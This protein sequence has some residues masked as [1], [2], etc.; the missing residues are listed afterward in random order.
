[1]FSILRIR[2]MVQRA[3]MKAY[4]KAQSEFQRE[5]EALEASHKQSIDSMAK[6]QQQNLADLSKRHLQ[7][8]KQLES[9]YQREIS[10]IQRHSD[11]IN[12]RLEAKIAQL[13]QTLLVRDEEISRLRQITEQAMVEEARRSLISDRVL[14][15][16]SLLRKTDHD[17]RA[18]QQEAELVTRQ[19]TKRL[20]LVR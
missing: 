10:A 17:L 12:Q 5:L 2:K 4:R 14:K 13:D 9:N 8:L 20:K 18:L 3:K 6:A 19:T 1:M 15:E 11:N 7:N 16:A